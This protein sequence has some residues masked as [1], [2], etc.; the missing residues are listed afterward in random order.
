MTTLEDSNNS[1]SIYAQYF[2]FK[3]LMKDF[4]IQIDIIDD[5]HFLWVNFISSYYSVNFLF[6][7]IL[8]FFLS[9]GLY[10]LVDGICVEDDCYQELTEA[11]SFL[12]ALV[13]YSNLAQNFHR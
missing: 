1:T 6:D 7:L 2:R 12:F 11:R 3:K 9:F 4:L 13:S 8:Y 5:H 10:F